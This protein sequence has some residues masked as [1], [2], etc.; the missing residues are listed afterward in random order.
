[1][2]FGKQVQITFTGPSAEIA[3]PLPQRKSTRIEALLIHHAFKVNHSI[4]TCIMVWVFCLGWC[5]SEVIQLEIKRS[6]G[7]FAPL[8]S[9][10]W[11]VYLLTKLSLYTDKHLVLLCLPPVRRKTS[12]WIGRKPTNI[13]QFW[14][15]SCNVAGQWCATWPPDVLPAK[16]FSS[17]TVFPWKAVIQW[18]PRS[19]QGCVE[20]VKTFDRIS[21]SVNVLLRP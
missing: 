20:Y 11:K 3:I 6:A 7:V 4:H 16:K 14:G 19:L 12:S 13:R 15:W 2:S 9:W 18:K 21:L 17:S 8:I 1:M 10:E 5:F